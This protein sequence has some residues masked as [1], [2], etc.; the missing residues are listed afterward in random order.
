MFNTSSP[1]SFRGFTFTAL[2]DGYVFQRFDPL[3]FFSHF[4]VRRDLAFADDGDAGFGGNARPK[5][6]GQ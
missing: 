6:C 3:E 4:F 2:G 5:T 1:E